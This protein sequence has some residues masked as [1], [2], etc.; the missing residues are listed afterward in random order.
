MWLLVDNYL[1][2]PNIENL[3]NINLMFLPPNTTSLLQSMAQ[4]VIHSLKQHYRRR[5]VRLC[6]KVLDKNMS[7]PNIL[8]VQDFYGTVYQR[9]PSSIV[10][11]KLVRLTLASSK[12]LI[13]DLSHFRE[14]DQNPIQE[15]LSA[16]SFIDSDNNVVTTLPTSSCKD[17]VAKILGPEVDKKIEE[18]IGDVGVDVGPNRPSDIELEEGLHKLYSFSPSV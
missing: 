11:R 17:I 7:R 13:E 5:I 8:M 6:I 1:G 18:D 2:H 3:S 10:L 15:E 12:A 9:R 16:E 14:I 4:V